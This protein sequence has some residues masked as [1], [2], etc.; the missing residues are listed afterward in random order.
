MSNSMDLN[1]I[2][3]VMALILGIGSLVDLGYTLVTLS[4]E[5]HEIIRCSIN[6]LISIVLFKYFKKRFNA[7]NELKQHDSTEESKAN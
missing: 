3:M 4:F 6:I 2:F 5:L 7:Q 1:K